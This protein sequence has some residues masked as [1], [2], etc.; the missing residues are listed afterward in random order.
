MDEKKD[1][2][3]KKKKSITKR[4]SIIRTK[5]Q[6]YNEGAEE[7]KNWLADSQTT[8]NQEAF[9]SQPKESTVTT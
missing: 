9:A 7:T 5:K 6:S 1:L 3:V 4:K 8:F 2:K